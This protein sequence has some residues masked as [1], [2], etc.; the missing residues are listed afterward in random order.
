MWI[1]DDAIH[2]D[3]TDVSAYKTPEGWTVRGFPELDG[4][5]LDRAA[6]VNALV[7]AALESYIDPAWNDKREIQSLRQE[8]G[9]S[10]PPS[11]TTD[12]PCD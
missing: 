11:T 8:L 3:V 10:T 6:A 2:S 4:R 12:R 1:T 5:I 9:I 7:L